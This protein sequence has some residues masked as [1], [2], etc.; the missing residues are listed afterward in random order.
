MAEPVPNL[1]SD[2]KVTHPETGALLPGRG[3]TTYVHW[4]G[5]KVLEGLEIAT[6]NVV[7]QATQS[8]A[9]IARANHPWN[10]DTGQLEA[11]IFAAEPEVKA[12]HIYAIWGAHFPALY[13]EYGTVK[14]DPFPF[15]RPA[16]D[17]AYRIA[18][19]AGA[20]RNEMHG[21]PGL[22]L[23]SLVEE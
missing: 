4:Y 2:F 5:G 23:I 16:A 6:Y 18:N 19:F 22:G 9:R 13:L 14:M 10:N 12:G 8:A 11:S 3:P 7:R 20:I 17:Q 21:S 15:L 1:P